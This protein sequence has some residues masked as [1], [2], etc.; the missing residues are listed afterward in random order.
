MPLLRPGAQ[1]VLIAPGHG[2]SGPDHWQTIWQKRHGYTRVEQSDWNLPER[3]AWVEKLALAVAA[4]P[5]PVVVVAHSLACAMV[6][7][8]AGEHP[9]SQVVAALLVAPAD[10]DSEMHTPDE[11]RSFA[12]LPLARLPFRSIVVASRTDPYVR[13]KRAEEMAERWGAR[14]VD[15]GR[16]GHINADAGFGEWPEGH[17]LL[18]EL[19]GLRA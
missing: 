16:V 7:H 11:V 1:T 10:V 14:L 3:S 6:V 9:T 5:G 19:L 17:L 4:A 13:F 12:P 18:E 2:S 15:A 8:F